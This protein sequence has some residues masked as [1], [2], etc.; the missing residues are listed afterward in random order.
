[1]PNRVAED[2]SGAAGIVTADRLVS[3]GVISSNIPSAGDITYSRFAE[4]QQQYSRQVNWQKPILDKLIDFLKLPLGWDSYKGVP[5]RYDTGMFGLQILGD[6]MTARTP[7]PE[8][9]PVSTGGVQFEWHQA[10]FDLELYIAAPYDAEL[11]FDDR[12]AG[13]SAS[14]TL[15]S[16]FSELL[17]KIQRLNQSR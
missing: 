10:D 9:I 6:V 8:V 17:Q 14:L 1:M 16:D 12:A 13:V 5:L 11:W 3:D 2:V 7:L 4:Y 15:G